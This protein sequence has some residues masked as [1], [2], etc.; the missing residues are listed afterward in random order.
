MSTKDH[1]P[2]FVISRTLSRTQEFM[3]NNLLVVNCLK[4][5]KKRIAT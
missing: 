3:E 2:T 1:S 5:K 4:K